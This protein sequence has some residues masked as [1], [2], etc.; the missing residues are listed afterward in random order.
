[1]HSVR[2]NIK[3][4]ALNTRAHDARKRS[5]SKYW[6]SEISGVQLS[7]FQIWCFFNNINYWYQCTIL[8]RLYY[9]VKRRACIIWND[10]KNYNHLQY[11]HVYVT[12]GVCR[13][14]YALRPRRRN[15]K[16]LQMWLGA[17]NKMYVVIE[18]L[19]TSIKDHLWHSRVCHTYII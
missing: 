11:L 4:W 3:I 12:P 5:W 15:E 14:S 8:A 10:A 18:P 6:T 2:K 13:I 7:I 17:H 9:A 19:G 16:M 1:M